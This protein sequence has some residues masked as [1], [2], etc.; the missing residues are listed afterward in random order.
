LREEHVEVLDIETGDTEEHGNL[1]RGSFPEGISSADSLSTDPAPA[2]PKTSSGISTPLNIFVGKPAS[3]SLAEISFT[4]PD[5]ELSFPP[6]ENSLSTSLT[7]LPPLWPEYDSHPP[8]T[9]EHVHQDDG[10]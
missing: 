4:S 2:I 10:V 7:P 5:S 9:S 3:P 8:D 1:T 6:L